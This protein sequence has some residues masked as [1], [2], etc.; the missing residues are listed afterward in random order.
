MS[1][2]KARKSTSPDLPD[3]VLERARQQLNLENGDDTAEQE[4]APKAVAASKPAPKP[5]A[6]VV[7]AT[8]SSADAARR[9]ARRRMDEPLQPKTRAKRDASDPAYVRDR[10]ENPTK[11]VTEE[12]LRHDYLYVLRDLRSMGLLAAG[13]MIL[14]AVLAQVLPK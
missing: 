8:P 1:K 2:R 14:V 10:L 11:F 5:A 6:S 13:L 7:R 4:E 12:E 3:S 9:P